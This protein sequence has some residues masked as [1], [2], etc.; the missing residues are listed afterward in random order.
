MEKNFEALKKIILDKAKAANACKGEYKR[1]Y[2]AKCIKEL[3]NVVKDNFEWCLNNKVIDANLIDEY[4]QEFAEGQIWHN[5]DV[6]I[7]YMLATGNASV[8]AFGSASVEASGS[9]YVINR[10]CVECNLSEYA[11][12]RLVKENKI[13]YASDDLSFEMVDGRNDLP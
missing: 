5:E 7:G 11:I 12:A 1:A 2:T 8:R 13:C 4:K 10:S 3:M 6:E 9:A